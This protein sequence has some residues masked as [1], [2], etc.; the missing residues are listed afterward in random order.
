MLSLTGLLAAWSF[1]ACAFVLTAGA[2]ATMSN[3][4]ALALAEAAHARGMGAALLGS[5]QFALGG[6]LAPLVGAWGERTAVPMGVV[7]LGAA[8][9]AGVCALLGARALPR[10]A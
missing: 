6:A 5:L 3:A 4:S 9:A 8:L 2:G 1:I 7:V 10:P